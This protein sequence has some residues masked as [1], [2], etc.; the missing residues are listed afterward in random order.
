MCGRNDVAESHRWWRWH[1]LFFPLIDP[2]HVHSFLHSINKYLLYR[3][4]SLVSGVKHLASCHA[5]TIYLAM[6]PQISGNVSVSYLKLGIIIVPVHWFTYISLKHKHSICFPALIII[7]LFP[8]YYVAII[9]Y[10]PSPFILLLL[11]ITLWY[12]LFSSN[13]QHLFF[14]LTFSWR[15][16]LLFEWDK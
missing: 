13:I 7:Q 12:L 8:Y 11:E 6:W 2:S 3:N 10:L 9:P 4:K 16:R 5:C 1:W 14:V 15:T